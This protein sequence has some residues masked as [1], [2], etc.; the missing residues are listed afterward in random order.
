MGSSHFGLPTLA[1]LLPTRMVSD[2]RHSV[3]ALIIN[4]H[5]MRDFRNQRGAS[6]VPWLALLAVAATAGV[7]IFRMYSANQARE[8]EIA[9]LRAELKELEAVRA[10]AQ[11]LPRLRAAADKM[12]AVKK[13]AEDL[14]RLRGE[15]TRL[16]VEQQ[17]FAKAQAEVQRLQGALQQQQ[18][19][20]AELRAQQAPATATAPPAG[21]PIPPEVQAAQTR[22]LR[23]ACIA[24]LKQLDGAKA[25]WALENKK[26]GSE[27][28]VDEDLFGPKLYIR[29]KPVCPANGSYLLLSVE[30]K[31]VCTVHGNA[32]VQ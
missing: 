25:T 4:S 14:P 19:Q 8:R 6:L 2:N 21:A 9:A 29:E 27:I 22:A 15:I 18:D 24:N 10:E 13:E 26:S 17:Q 12:E 23:N 16:R 28:P 1:G 5:Q 11:E 32:L 7:V 3:A 30:T 20:A 31:P